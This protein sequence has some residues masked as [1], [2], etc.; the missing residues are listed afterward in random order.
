MVSYT[1]IIQKPVFLL[2][3]V[4]DI[5]HTVKMR[6]VL[7]PEQT[8]INLF[9]QTALGQSLASCFSTNILTIPVSFAQAL[10]VSRGQTQKQKCQAKRNATFTKYCQ[11][12][13]ESDTQF[14]LLPIAEPTHP[15]QY[16]VLPEIYIF[17]NMMGVKLSHFNFPD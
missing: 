13:H 1:C 10:Q 7:V 9:T 6:S 15:H 12:A 11:I 14:I 3:R 2:N 16:L 8:P 5:F 17:A 4:F